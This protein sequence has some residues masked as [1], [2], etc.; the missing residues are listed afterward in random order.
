MGLLDR[1]ERG[2][3]RAVNGAF[4][5]V[6]RSGV[7]PLEIASALRKELDTRAAIVARDRILVPHVLTVSL[8]EPDYVRMADLG[9]TLIAELTELITEHAAEQRYHFAGP[10]LI[11]LQQQ[12]GLAEGLLRVG[13]SGGSGQV[14]W[15]PV[16]DV[17]AK[18]HPLATGGTVIGRGAEADVV[19]DDNGASRLHAEVNW[20]GKRAQL[21]DLG[22]TNGTRL[23]GERINLAELSPNSVITIGRT[24]LVYRML[25]QS[26]DEGRSDDGS[27]RRPSRAG[28][29]LR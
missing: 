19:L 28:G 14:S 13:S 27:R 6:F 5:K 4:A 11:R 10:L 2:L 25:A 21:R 17:G 16:L 29:G 22:S 7:Q 1:M 15:Y 18:R 26:H 24:R 12:E 8:S 3:E 9:D 23:N 20:D